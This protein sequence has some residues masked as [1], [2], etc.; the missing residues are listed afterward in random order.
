[1]LPESL[2]ED[3]P[4]YLF[5]KR[6]AKNRQV[7][8]KLLSVGVETAGGGT[9]KMYEEKVLNRIV[10]LDTMSVKDAQ[11]EKPCL[12]SEEPLLKEPQRLARRRR[13]AIA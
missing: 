4:A 12:P 10:S 6:K 5:L 2:K 8:E 11:G 9:S 7:V 3:D 13:G 1:M